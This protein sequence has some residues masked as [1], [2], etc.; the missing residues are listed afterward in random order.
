MDLGIF[1]IIIL[2]SNVRSLK[3]MKEG[4]PTQYTRK[5]RKEVS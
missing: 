4:S 3:Y 5:L 2:N 1:K